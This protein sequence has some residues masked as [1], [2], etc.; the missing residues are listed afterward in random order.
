MRGVDQ[1][2]FP[3]AHIPGENLAADLGLHFHNHIASPLLNPVGRLIRHG[4]GRGAFFG[5][6]G[7]HTQ[8]VEAGFAYKVTQRFK[9]FV[10]FAGKTDDQT[11]A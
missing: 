2:G 10:R 8:M 7:E 9:V 3:A 11:G 1:N 5:L 4:R 6:I